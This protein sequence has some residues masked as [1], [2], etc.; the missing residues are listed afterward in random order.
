MDEEG[1]ELAL[2]EVDAYEDEGEGLEVGGAGG[3]G[4]VGEDSVEER[5]D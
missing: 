4:G 3:V 1:F 2:C 5:V